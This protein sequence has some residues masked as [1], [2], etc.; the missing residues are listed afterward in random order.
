MAEKESRGRPAAEQ[1]THGEAVDRNSTEQ[2]SSSPETAPTP[3]YEDSVEFL[4]RF[5]PDGPWCLVAIEER[6]DRK[7]TST[8]TLS[9]GE[10]DKV[11]HWLRAVGE[12]SNCYFCVNPVRRRMKKK[13]KASDIASMRGCTST[14][15]RARARTSTRSAR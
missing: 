11:R 5:A 3:N 14:S 15:T 1:G 13:P 8:V 12:R 10:E 6:E 4:R 9:P 7:T 2:C